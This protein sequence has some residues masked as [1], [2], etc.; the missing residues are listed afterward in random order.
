MPSNLFHWS[1]DSSDDEASSPGSRNQSS[2]A[3]DTENSANTS[4]STPR[5]AN[6][7]NTLKLASL[8]VPITKKIINLLSD[9]LEFTKLQILQSI[10]VTLSSQET[11]YLD[12]FFVDTD[13]ELD[14]EMEYLMRYWREEFMLRLKSKQQ[15]L[16]DD[17]I[18]NKKPVFESQSEKEARLQIAALKHEISHMKDTAHQKEQEMLVLEAMVERREKMIEENRKLFY[19]ELLMLK[20]DHFKQLLMGN[21]EFLEHEKLVED[22]PRDLQTASMYYNAGA[23]IKGLKKI[24]SL[25]QQLEAQHKEVDKARQKHERMAQ[26]ESDLLEKLEQSHKDTQNYMAEYEIAK[27]KMMELQ[28]TVEEQNETLEMTNSQL[29]SYKNHIAELE[30]ENAAKSEQLELIADSANQIQHFRRKSETLSADL[31]EARA[32]ISSLNQEKMR[33]DSELS[34]LSGLQ[35]ENE[36]LVEKV[37]K[38]NQQILSQTETIQQLN[39]ELDAARNEHDDAWSEQ[40]AAQRSRTPL[41]RDGSDQL[42]TMMNDAELAQLDSGGKDSPLMRKFGF[43]SRRQSS[44]EYH[45]PRT[46]PPPSPAGTGSKSQL[47]SHKGGLSK[48]VKLQKIKTSDSSFG[49]L[50]RWSDRDEDTPKSIMSRTSNTPYDEKN[51]K[52]PISNIFFQKRRSSNIEDEDLRNTFG[53]VADTLEELDDIQQSGV[54]PG[55]KNVSADILS[56][57]EAKEDMEAKQKERAQY[58]LKQYYLFREKNEVLKRLE[59][60]TKLMYERVRL[61]K[62]ILEQQKQE[63]IE[64]CLSV[65]QLLSKTH[66]DEATILERQHLRHLR[67][68]YEV[69]RA[70]NKASPQPAKVGGTLHNQ[71]LNVLRNFQT[72]SPSMSDT[73]RPKS[74]APSMQLPGSQNRFHVTKRRV[75]LDERSMDDMFRCRTVTPPPEGGARPARPHTSNSMG[76]AQSSMG[77]GNTPQKPRPA[78]TSPYAAAYHILDTPTQKEIENAPTASG[79]HL[80]G[81]R[82]PLIPTSSAFR[83]ASAPPELHE[84]QDRY[85]L[86]KKLRKKPARSGAKSGRKKTKKSPKRKGLFEA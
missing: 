69:V 39:E 48:K 83:A 55:R 41:N 24:R 74:A 53:V 50:N 51:L 76:R 1:A 4:T 66:P 33:R 75:S 30:A 26:K 68:E 49:D 10:S 14:G 23:V 40:S 27:A 3:N 77:S 13:N 31:N 60:R 52:N 21:F 17:Y 6:I 71:T 35:D 16:V 11:T 2:H 86:E 79:M 34:E 46:K 12:K 54:S 61:K 29:Q 80:S 59:K 28:S 47:S 64:R 20:E 36:L 81:E 44:F 5:G 9:H 15:L 57:Q 62:S 82:P 25:E 85:R 72:P 8:P 70:K 58:L 43:A 19:R 42:R 67:E 38:L 84:K 73:I 78:T 63:Q 22:I 45:S 32:K 65:F 7:P 18:P 37:D 56:P